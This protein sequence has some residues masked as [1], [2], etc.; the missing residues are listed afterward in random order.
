[1]IQ[2]QTVS[3]GKFSH[4]GNDCFADTALCSE[5][6]VSYVGSSRCYTLPS[7]EILNPFWKKNLWSIFNRTHSLCV[8]SDIFLVKWG[9]SLS[10]SFDSFSHPIRSIHPLWA[11]YLFIWHFFILRLC[12]SSFVNWICQACWSFIL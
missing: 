2:C 7:S 3:P 9:S 1:M 11:S 5:S 10:S 4:G 12:W 6:S 8:L